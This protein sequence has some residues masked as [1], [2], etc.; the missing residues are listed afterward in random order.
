[1]AYHKNAPSPRKAPLEPEDLE[2][3]WH[4][5]SRLKEVRDEFNYCLPTATIKPSSLDAYT[6]H[7]QGV[8]A[9]VEAELLNLTQLAASANATSTLE[10][11]YKAKIAYAMAEVQSQKEL[12][13]LMASL[14]TDIRTL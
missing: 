14:I 12:Q 13:A 11:T 4:K 6:R 5:F 2:R 10:L 8:I 9:S 1:M 7:D 3:I